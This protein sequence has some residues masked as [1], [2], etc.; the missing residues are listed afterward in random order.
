MDEAQALADRVAVI[1]AGRIVAS[2]PPATIGGRDS[3]RKRIR[4]VLPA[5]TEP[6][7]LPLPVTLDDGGTVTAEVDEPTRALHELTGWALARGTALGGLSIERPS[8]EDVYLSLTGPP[9][10]S[11]ESAASARQPQPTGGSKS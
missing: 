11:E 6:A 3:A 10:R 8:L 4:F 9:G 5:G 2:G 1:V 7:D